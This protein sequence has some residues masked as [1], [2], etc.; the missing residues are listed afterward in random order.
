MTKPTLYAV[1]GPSL[2]RI[3]K[4]LGMAGLLVAVCATGVAAQQPPCAGCVA[5]TISTRQAALLPAHLDG[6]DVLVTLEPEAM[7]PAVDALAAISARGGHGGIVIA[8][9]P[10]A[11]DLPV[12]LL[13]SVDRVLSDLTLLPPGSNTQQVAY[14]LKN[15][16]TA[17][18]GAGKPGIQFGILVRA[19]DGPRIVT[20]D[21]APYLDFVVWSGAPSA[22]GAGTAVW[23]TYPTPPAS[24]AA[25]LAVTSTG[26][27]DRWLWQ[28]PVD[29]G[30]AEPLI[31][32]IVEAA[33]LLPS[34]LVPAPQVE[35][36]CAS[37]RAEAYRNPQTL[38]V[39]AFVPTCPQEMEVA[40]TPA[41]PGIR[42]V[43]LATGE[44]IVTVP[45]HGAGDQ[46]AEGVQVVGARSLSVEEIL[47]RHQAVAAR[48]RTAVTTLI[49]RGTLTLSFE[50]PGFP[51]PIAISSDS[52]I[53]AGDGV[54]ELEQRAIRINGIEFKGGG[55]PRLPIIE[56]ERVASPPLTIT[57]TDLYRYKLV[58]RE[59]IGGTPCYLV[60][61]DP[62]GEA[63]LFRGRAWIA[64][65]S[66]AMLRVAA[67]QTRLRGPIV[68]S[69]Q[70]DDFQQVR[71]GVWLLERSDVRQTY[72]GASYRTPIHRVLAIESQ[73]I[74]SPDFVVRRAAARASDAVM[75]RDTSDG[76]RYLKRSPVA[77]AGTAPAEPEVVGRANHVR[78]LALGV[79][80][81]PNISVPLPFAGVS[82]VDFNL[83]G[84]GTQLSVFFGGTYGQL[85]FSVPSLFG[86]RW[87]LAGRAFGIASSYNDRSFLNGREDYTR[88]IRQRPA[89]ASFWLL[90]SLT[91]LVSVRLGYDV[92][93]TRLTESDS[94][95][96]T[97]VVP[98]DQ[99]V[100][101]ARV[102]LDLQRRGWNGSLW[103]NP[104]LRSGWRAWGPL[105]AA[106]YSTRQNDFQRYGASVARSAVIN[107]RVVARFEGAWMSGHDLDRFSRY[108]FGTFDNRLRGYP[109]ALIRY[110]Q[111]AVLRSA[112]AWSPG[113]LVRI[114]G[115]VDSAEVHDPGFGR[116]VRNYTGVG[117]AAELPAPFGTLLALEWGYGFRGVNGDGTLGTQVVRVSAF[118][119]F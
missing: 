24:L 16:S 82:Y 83:L 117:A 22:E 21:V 35:V 89:Q 39:I 23:R 108:T 18:R 48:Q 92:D 118:K 69:E 44:L 111:G 52:T 94:T 55:V 38:D 72:E 7:Q 88:N 66:F 68:A 106:E 98:A 10:G 95:A 86:S 113:K 79:I 14:A 73:E 11:A 119:V 101:G 34:G 99:I 36:T 33:R 58:G 75:L 20:P 8:G 115:F 67:V 97:F 93:Y 81:D 78:T 6:L 27:A 4:R 28:M 114:D 13:A 74:N 1:A 17:I 85:A 61:F 47:A 105:G 37:K 102:A 96:P 43:R 32:A 45:P 29:D 65:D 19:D 109:S 104:A 77:P 62:V 60:E 49:S 25:A 15:G 76:Y 116:G 90:R 112:V 110:D 59:T 103:W 12:S 80:L 42:Q 5:L 51:A 84:T 53:Y 54:T 46:F 100:H 30:V 9:L 107:P 31:G 70:V 56:P 63:T 41:V 57:L 71:E 26:G 91:P 50:A 64:M 2:R 3:A 87:Q 40:V